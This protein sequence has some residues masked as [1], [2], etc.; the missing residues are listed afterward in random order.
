M[1]WIDA[2]IRRKTPDTIPTVDYYFLGALSD[3]VAPSG[4]PDAGR[5]IARTGPHTFVRGDRAVVV[6]Y[7]TDEEVAMLG[8]RSWERVFYVVDD[9]LP[10]ASA[11][12]E[13]PEDYR[14]RLGRFVE[15]TLPKI[16]AFNPVIVAPRREI[17][18]LFPGRTT[19]LLDPCWIN[20]ATSY[21]HFESLE[22]GGILNVA[23][24]GTRSHQAGVAFVS[25]ILRLLDAADFNKKVRVSFFLGKALPREIRA[26]AFVDN[27]EPMRWSDY[28]RVVERE[29]FHV[30]LAPL[31]DTPFNAGRS[32][33]K[34]LDVAAVGAA[35]LF[36]ERD[37]FRSVV[38]HG[39]DGMLLPD[40]APAWVAALQHILEN[41]AN[42]VALAIGCRRL[43]ETTGDPG[44]VRNFWMSRLG[45]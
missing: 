25:E 21:D 8:R 23:F 9:M 2:V 40:D 16:L 43:A 13:L 6:R 18:A 5:P 26:R 20:L 38:T 35:G 4:R 37:P 41:P 24:M 42:A 32:I 28:R 36:S 7:V 45:L 44:R 17:L 15:T 22:R 14:R 39:R 19:E 33:T 27:R 31:P 12:E 11:C 10:L 30:V 3:L 34:V 1:R 29:R